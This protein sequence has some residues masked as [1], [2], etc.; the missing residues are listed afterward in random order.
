MR[1]LW[2]TAFRRV[3][4]TPEKLSVTRA[5]DHFDHTKE[6]HSPGRSPLTSP[7]HRGPGTPRVATQ[8]NW[9]RGNSISCLNGSQSAMR[10]QMVRPCAF[11]HVWKSLCMVGGPDMSGRE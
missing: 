7:S 6:P 3:R 10:L 2:L 1:D 5:Q 11:L 4:G 8:L 9:F